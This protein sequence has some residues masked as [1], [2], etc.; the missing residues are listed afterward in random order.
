[1]ARATVARR[2]L[3]GKFFEKFLNNDLN[4]LSTFLQ[5]KYKEI[6]A[7]E[8]RGVTPLNS[9][10]EEFWVESGSLSTVK[11][12]EYNVFQFY[13]VEIYN[14][15][16]GIRDTVKEACEYYGIDFKKQQYM[17]Q[18]WFNINTSKG[19]KLDWHDHGGPY[20][21]YFHG[22]YCVNAEPSIT[23]YKINNDD[24]QIVDNININNRLILSEMGHPHAQGN[25][26]WDGPRITIAFDVIPLAS[27]GNAPEQ[28]LIPLI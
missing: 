25:W 16:V 14:L 2:P 28:H 5:L 13:S 12:R 19:G 24:N 18:G 1:M 17:L 22:F 11:W 9:Q 6:A 27:V 3:R 26:D 23:H 20:A 15:F 4:N 21:P 8:V 10:H 7:S